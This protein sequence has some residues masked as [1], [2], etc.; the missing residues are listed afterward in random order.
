MIKSQMIKVL[1]FANLA[2]TCSRFNLGF[3][4]IWLPRILEVRRWAEEGITIVSYDLIQ[5][6]RH[7]I[8]HSHS[9]IWNK[10]ILKG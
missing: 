2:F 1:V 6:D 9:L 5:C 8:A 4:S 3:E 10:N 7:I